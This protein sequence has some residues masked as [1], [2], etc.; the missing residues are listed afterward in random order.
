MGRNLNVMGYPFPQ[1]TQSA[2]FLY[3]YPFHFLL[4]I[5]QACHNIVYLK[6]KN[7]AVA[8]HEE[9]VWLAGN[10][11]LEVTEYSRQIY[12]PDGYA[13]HGNDVNDDDDGDELKTTLTYQS[14]KRHYWQ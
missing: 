3:L 2:S 13:Y 7:P 10:L 12:G 1:G 14:R 4:C 8:K 5:P 9:L 11:K 6:K